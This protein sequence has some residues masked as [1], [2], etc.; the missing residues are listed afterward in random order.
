MKLSVLCVFTSLIYFTAAAVV[1]V[2][3]HLPEYT[4]TATSILSSL[5]CE[6]YECHSVT[7][8]HPKGHPFCANMRDPVCAAVHDADVGANAVDKKLCRW[9]HKMIGHPK[10]PCGFHPV[11]TIPIKNPPVTM[12]IPS[13]VRDH[14]E[15]MGGAVELEAGRKEKQRRKSRQ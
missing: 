1:P 5:P 11:K 2:K 4:P 10:D 7:E 9:F 14:K 12:I 8:R 3:K 15:A 13:A 6:G